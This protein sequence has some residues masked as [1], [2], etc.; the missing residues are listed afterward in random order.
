MNWLNLDYW[1]ELLRPL[2]PEPGMAKDFG[3]A[4]IDFAQPVVE[5]GAQCF[6][7]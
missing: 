4:M 5:I 2:I 7:V 1:Y 3:L 6:W